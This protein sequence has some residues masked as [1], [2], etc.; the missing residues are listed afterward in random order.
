MIKYF[1]KLEVALFNIFVD[2]FKTAEILYLSL[3]PSG[4]K[5]YFLFSWE[6]QCTLNQGWKLEENLNRLF[7]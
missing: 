7:R 4:V 5:Y 1:P 3:Y 6:S 2:L